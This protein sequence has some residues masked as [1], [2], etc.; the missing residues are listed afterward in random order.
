MEGPK[1]GED[2]QRQ[3]CRSSSPFLKT[4]QDSPLQ[5]S[6]LENLNNLKLKLRVDCFQQNMFNS[7]MIIS[8]PASGLNAK[9][10]SKAGRRQL[11]GVQNFCP[12]A[13]GRAGHK[14]LSIKD[15]ISEWEG[16]RELTT[17]APGRKADGQEDYLTSCVTD[18]RCGDGVMTQFTAA[19]NGT[20]PERESKENERNKEVVEVVGQNAER[21]LDLSQPARELSPSMGKGL[22]LRLSKQ[23]FQND[24]LSVLVQ[25]KKLEQALKDGVAGLDL[26]LPG[27]CY[28]PHC[29]PDK[30][31]PS[32]TGNRGCGS[33]SEF[34]SHHLDLEARQPTPEVAEEW[35]GSYGKACDQSLESVYRG[36]SSKHFIN[37]LPKPRRT[38]MHDGEGDKDG[39]PGISFR[40]DRRNLPPLPT[41]PP[42][43]LP[44]SPPPPSV[45]RRLWNGR[46]KPN[47]DHR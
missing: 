3:P 32:L 26:Q 20:R 24:S 22:E 46:P 34:R 8:D 19:E 15:K 36:S 6:P 31:G 10:A 12:P 28:S 41:L 4:D 5:R 7:N 47:A 40:K 39:S 25:V 27:T 30:E 44:S 16:K 9:E 14:S 35:R 21:R 42:P 37:P 23:R 45:N 43:P 17:P 1:A 18:R 2:L 33:G 13:R 29:V 38:F 11:S